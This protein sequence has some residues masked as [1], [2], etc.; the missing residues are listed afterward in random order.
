MFKQDIDNTRR[1]ENNR[2]VVIGDWRDMAWHMT[3]AVQIWDALHTGRLFKQNILF[4][5][6]AIYWITSFLD[7]SLQK[8]KNK[9][10]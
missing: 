8:Q 10:K 6:K 2:R 3:G 5:I 1:R 4:I 7:F 9:E